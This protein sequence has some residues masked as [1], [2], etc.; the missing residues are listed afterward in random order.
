VYH[1][2]SNA[3]ALNNVNSN[4]T[5]D[6]AKNKTEHSNRQLAATRSVSKPRLPQREQKQRLDVRQRRKLKPSP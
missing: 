2:S 4:T 6:F 5:V 3:Y 1:P